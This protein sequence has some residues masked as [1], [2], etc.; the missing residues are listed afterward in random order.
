MLSPL[1]E[2]LLAR[3][4]DL[5]MPRRVLSKK[6]GV[7][8]KMIQHYEA[9]R[10]RPKDDVLRRLAESLEVPLDWLEGVPQAVAASTPLGR[11]VMWDGEAERVLREAVSLGQQAAEV[12]GRVAP[13]ALTPEDEARIEADILATEG[14]VELDMSERPL[15]PEEEAVFEEVAGE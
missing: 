12:L 9:G 15:T 8:A 7:S 1:A 5:R 10:Y 6:A 2:R 3:R 4:R 11:L 14:L 13:R